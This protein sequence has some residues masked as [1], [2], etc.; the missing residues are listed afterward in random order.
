MFL[1]ASLK[2]LQLLE[3]Y[4]FRIGQILMSVYAQISA[5]VQLYVHNVNICSILNGDSTSNGL[6]STGHC[7]DAFWA[8]VS[9]VAK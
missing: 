5:N 9:C 2:T 6:T 1:N 7:F 8:S 3:S 4:D